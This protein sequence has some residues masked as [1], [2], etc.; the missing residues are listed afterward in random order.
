MTQHLDCLFLDNASLLA[1]GEH[2]L[3]TLSVE[4]L[5]TV[6]ERCLGGSIGGHARHCVEF[7]RSFLV[8]VDAGQVDYDARPRDWLIESDPES[9]AE[10]L[11]ELG[12]QLNDIAA[13][14]EL[15]R[16]VQ[17]L[18]NHAGNAPQWSVSSV[19]RELRFLLSHTVHHYALI[20]ILLRLQG[21]SVP[22]DFGVAPST[23]RHRSKQ[24]TAPLCAQ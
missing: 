13:S 5:T 8:G 21:E 17:I 6:D 1:A 4:R 19:S 10:A 3:R 7:Y 23:L 16:E 15:D 18:E 24:A 22:P 20:A 9:A 14:L 11:R 12:L 2:L